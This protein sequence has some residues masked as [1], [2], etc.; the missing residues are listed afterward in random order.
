[1]KKTSYFSHDSNARNDEKILAVRMKYG[2]EGYGIYFMILERLRDSDGYMSIKDYNMLAFDFRVSAE[3]VK[4]IV[5][6]FGLFVFTE[7][8]KH[9][10]SESFL[11]RMKLKD[12]K[13]LKARESANQRWRKK[14]EEQKEMRTQ[15]ERIKNECER[16]ASKV[17]KSKVNNKEKEKEKEKPKRFL[18]PSL[19]EVENYISEK[20]YSV[21]A[22]AFIAFYTAKNWFIGK[23]KMKDWRAAIVTWQKR[24]NNKKTNHSGVIN[25]QNIEYKP[26]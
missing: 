14:T 13:S 23:N 2:A 19:D 11:Q 10:Y 24:E 8:S 25:T 9:F 7:D 15:C 26:F 1:M 12:E 4:S 5:E 3:K 18:P 22:E 17:K 21:D 16:N 20:G 6:D